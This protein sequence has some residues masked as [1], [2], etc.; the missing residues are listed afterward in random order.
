M[1]LNLVVFLFG[2]VA[3]VL[4]GVSSFFYSRLHIVLDEND[5]DNFGRILAYVY[6][7]NGTFVNKRLLEL[8]AG[9]FFYSRPA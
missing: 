9:E 8:G 7:T 5:R 6:L 1:K 3:L 2:I 4:V